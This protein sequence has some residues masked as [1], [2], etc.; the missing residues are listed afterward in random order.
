MI[1]RIAITLFFASTALA[2]A[3][4]CKSISDPTLATGVFRR[5]QGR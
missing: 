4:D 3:T 1:L 2:V 5:A